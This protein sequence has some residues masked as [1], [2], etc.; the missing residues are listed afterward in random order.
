MS[1]LREHT[2]PGKLLRL[3]VGVAF[4]AAS[5]A[6][7]W[8]LPA[9]ANAIAAATGARLRSLPMSPPKVLAA[10]KAKAHG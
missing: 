8:P 6:L 9:L 4:V 7:W 10:I 2:L 1:E 5:A 3:A